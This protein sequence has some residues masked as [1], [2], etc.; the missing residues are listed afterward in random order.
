MTVNENDSTGT[1]GNSA[2]LSAETSLAIHQSSLRPNALGGIPSNYLNTTDLASHRNLESQ[3]A[4]LRRLP[5]KQLCLRWRAVFARKAPEDLPRALL[6]RVFVYKLQAE[7]KGDLSPAT[8]SLLDRLNSANDGKGQALSSAKLPANVLKPGSILVREY[9][10]ISH[11][12]TVLERGFNWNGRKFS[13]LS[14][15]AKVM[16]GTN[17]NGPRFFGIRAKSG[18]KA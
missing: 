2:K 3:V 16:T 17:W 18:G 13:S 6:L 12:V 10:G 15:L 11:R 4:E 1:V 9:G 14:Q 5:K 8:I 7:I